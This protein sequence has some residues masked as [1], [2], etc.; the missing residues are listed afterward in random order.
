M[1]DCEKR[2]R[3]LLDGWRFRGE[4]PCRKK[5]CKSNV[6]YWQHPKGKG[7]AILSV[8]GLK[9]HWPECTGKSENPRQMK[10]FA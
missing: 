7:I 4:G 8:I 10:L 6:E 1:L 3:L 5:G 9:P 2:S